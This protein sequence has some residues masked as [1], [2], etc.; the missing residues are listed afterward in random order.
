MTAPIMVEYTSMTVTLRSTFLQ[1]GGNKNDECITH[2]T[3][4]FI[5]ALLHACR[6][7]HGTGKPSLAA[8]TAGRLNSKPR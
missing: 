8:S 1:I 5:I 3:G 7:G 2:H 6:L 4:M